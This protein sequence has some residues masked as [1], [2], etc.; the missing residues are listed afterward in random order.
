M[1]NILSWVL[2]ALGGKIALAL[3][4]LSLLLGVA[5][6]LLWGD[7]QEQA[8]HIGKLEGANKAQ[9]EAITVLEANRNATDRALL[10]NEGKREQIYEEREQAREV[11]E[12]KRQT[13]EGLAVWLDTPLPDDVFRLLSKNGSADASYKTDPAGGS[14][15]AK[16]GTD[17]ARENK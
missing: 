8:T 1:G 11:I 15:A 16:A 5:L 14:A 9:Q 3:C 12:V 17:A 10:E 2:E 6:W 13:N 4:V 7:V